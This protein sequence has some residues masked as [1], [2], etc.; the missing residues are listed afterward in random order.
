MTV[1]T[2]SE[3]IGSKSVAVVYKYFVSFLFA[4]YNAKDRRALVE[5]SLI[6]SIKFFEKF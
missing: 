2:T 1:R 5:E 4:N 3:D 6:K